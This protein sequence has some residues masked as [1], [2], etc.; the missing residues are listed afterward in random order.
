MIHYIHHHH[1]QYRMELL[2]ILFV[3]I[4]CF[5]NNIQITTAVASTVPLS[6]ENFE[7]IT[8]INNGTN[9]QDWF[10]MFHAPWC[11]H[12]KKTM[13]AFQKASSHMFKKKN[14]ATVNIDRNQ[15]LGERFKV[16][17]LPTLIMFSKGKMYLYRSQH[18]E[19][20]DLVKFADGGFSFQRPLSIPRDFTIIQVIWKIIYKD[21][22]MTLYRMYIKAPMPTFLNLFIGM[23][24]GAISMFLI[25]KVAMMQ[26]LDDILNKQERKK[27]RRKLKKAKRKK[28]L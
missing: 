6:Y 21:V 12:C 22:I 26:Q 7:D 10:V 19:L 13:P 4:I 9:H 3:G 8:Q 23:V 11:K 1:I 16:N 25:M 28:D 15:R 17:N 18:R 5:L 2:F 27:F 20:S 14:F 24:I